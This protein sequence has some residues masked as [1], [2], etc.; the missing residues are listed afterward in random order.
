MFIQVALQVV[1]VECVAFFVLCVALALH[2]K[3]LIGEVDVSVAS[4]EVVLG[5]AR[6][7]VPRLVKVD[8]EVVRDNGPHS[9]VELAPVEEER[10]LYVLLHHPGLG[11]WIS[12]ENVLVHVAQVSE[13]L[14]SSALV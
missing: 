6:S 8:T 12:V 14:D 4:F 5:R 9:N 1:V 3:A 11:L 10:M 2:L 7:K 13:K